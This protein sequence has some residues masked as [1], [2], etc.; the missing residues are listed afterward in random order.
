MVHPLV[1]GDVTKVFQEA[2]TN[3]V[4]QLLACRPLRKLGCIGLGSHNII[5]EVIFDCAILFPPR[6]IKA[7]P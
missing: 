3:Q 1:G 2:D 4:Q 5:D 7:S 6:F